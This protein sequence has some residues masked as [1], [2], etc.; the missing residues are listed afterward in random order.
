[1]QPLVL[2]K[3][4]LVF[5][6][7]M[8]GQKPSPY[9]TGWL[10]ISAAPTTGKLWW[11]MTFSNTNSTCSISHNLNS[12]NTTALSMIVTCT[13]VQHLPPP[14]FSPS[15]HQVTFEVTSQPPHKH[16]CA[17]CFQCS[18]PGHLPSECK[19]KQTVTSKLVAPIISS[20]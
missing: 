4:G 18:A 10:W 13:L 17:C 15:K 8:S 11:S 2:Q 16:T 7:V 6:M 5:I 19:A 1:M 3:R 12:L 14:A 9:T 20:T